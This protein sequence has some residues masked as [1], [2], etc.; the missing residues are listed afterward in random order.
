MTI[1]LSIVFFKLRNYVTHRGIPI[2]ILFD[3][4]DKNGFLFTQT[5][6]FSNDLLNK[7]DEW[8]L[9]KN[10]LI[11]RETIMIF[12]SIFAFERMKTK[13]WNEINSFLLQRFSQPAKTL[14]HLLDGVGNLDTNKKLCI[15]SYDGEGNDLIYLRLQRGEE[16][17]YEEKALK[18][19]I[20][21]LILNSQNTE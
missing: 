12:P 5:W 21:K 9:V 11:S 14:N 2:N 10:D 17:C 19:Y 1:I 13:F 8:G 18:T 4:T 16:I 20:L 3:G 15:L 6:Y 7:Y